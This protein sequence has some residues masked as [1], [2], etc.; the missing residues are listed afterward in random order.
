MNG[1]HTIEFDPQGIIELTLW[2]ELT[3]DWVPKLIHEVRPVVQKYHCF[4]VLINLQEVEF[5]LSVVDLYNL[6]DLIAKLTGASGVSISAFK[7][8]LVLKQTD[9]LF[10]FFETTAI[11]RGHR[12]RMFQDVEAARKWLLDH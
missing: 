4:R 3:T 12:V 5:K 8:A 11:N 10:H 2:G 7:R 9:S 6:P 1:A